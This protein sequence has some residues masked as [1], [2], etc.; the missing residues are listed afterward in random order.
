MQVACGH[1]PSDHAM[2]FALASFAP[3]AVVAA[4]TEDTVAAEGTSLIA[5]MCQRGQAAIHRLGCREFALAFV[6]PHALPITQRR[7]R[8][9]CIGNA[10]RIAFEGRGILR[11]KTINA[12]HFAGD[13]SATPAAE[14]APSRTME[15]ALDSHGAPAI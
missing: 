10:A 12:S 8:G 6:A 7:K 15:P 1:C 5:A 2:A 4:N 14:A 13:M 3:L 9:H 11:C